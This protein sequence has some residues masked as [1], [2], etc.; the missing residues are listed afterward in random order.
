MPIDLFISI[1]LDLAQ[2]PRMAFTH[3]GFF[4]WK[5]RRAVSEGEVLR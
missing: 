3:R 1:D 4:I 2:N 5:R